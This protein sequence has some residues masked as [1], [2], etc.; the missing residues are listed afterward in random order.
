MNL[1]VTH[2]INSDLISR[3]SIPLYYLIR[4]YQEQ[5]QQ[6]VQS[7]ISEQ[8]DPTIAQRLAAAFNELSTDIT[9]NSERVH[10]LKFQDNFDKFIINVQ[11][12]LMIK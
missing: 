11:G 8:A 9:F 10:M 2:Q 1:I 7:L 3:T 4:C 5:Y 12:F 6:L